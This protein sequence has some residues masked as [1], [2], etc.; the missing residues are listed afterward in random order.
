ME[1]YP[2]V[3]MKKKL[4]KCHNVLPEIGPFILLVREVFKEL[5]PL[6]SLE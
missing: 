3:K 5:V 1:K 4:M 2:W 6:P